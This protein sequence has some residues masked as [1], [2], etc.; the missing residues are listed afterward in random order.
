MELFY[1]KGDKYDNARI[2]CLSVNG[3]T[4]WLDVVPNNLY[5]VKYDNQEMWVLLSLFFGC[6]ISNKDKLCFKNKQPTDR[7]GYHALHCPKGPHV[8]NRHNRIRDTIN[9][10]MKQS[11]FNTKI[12]QK[13]KYDE[14]KQEMVGKDGKIPG[15]IL[16]YRFNNGKDV[17]FD[18]VVGNRQ[19]L[20]YT[21][22]Q[23]YI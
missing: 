8:I 15:D 23:D 9:Q 20:Y 22:K 19:N 11:G 2:R 13:Y 17:Y 10:Y 18:V 14:N 7:K 16:A 3:A 5:G 1:D 12:E 21:S 6:D 4:S